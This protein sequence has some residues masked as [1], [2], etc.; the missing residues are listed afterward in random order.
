MLRPN[1]YTNHHALIPMELSPARGGEKSTVKTCKQPADQYSIFFSFIKLCV[2]YVYIPPI[3][4]STSD[5]SLLKAC[6]T[7]VNMSLSKDSVNY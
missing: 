2:M 6:N 1:C 4:L 3:V 5:Q 7:F